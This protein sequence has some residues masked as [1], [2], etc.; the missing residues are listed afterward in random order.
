MCSGWHFD[1]SHGVHL[2]SHLIFC[3]WCAIPQKYEFLLIGHFFGPKQSDGA[4]ACRVE[5]ATFETYFDGYNPVSLLQIQD[6]HSFRFVTCAFSFSAARLCRKHLSNSKYCDRP[7]SER[8]VAKTKIE[9]T[10]SSTKALI[11]LCM[12]SVPWANSR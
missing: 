5:S 9:P 1:Q 7:K 11:S 10:V 8:L 12:I 6:W 4:I 2:I 3:L